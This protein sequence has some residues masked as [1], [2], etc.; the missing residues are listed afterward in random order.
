M[1]G[2]G[3]GRYNRNSGSGES[4]EDSGLRGIME[5]GNGAHNGERS[6]MPLTPGGRRDRE[7]K[8]KLTS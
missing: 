8:F 3:G 1:Q 7:I 4:Q 2:G 5:N 6:P